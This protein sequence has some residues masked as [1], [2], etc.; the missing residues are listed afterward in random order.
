METWS[1]YAE[2]KYVNL[3]KQL[4]DPNTDQLEKET[5][6]NDIE[7]LENQYAKYA[8]YNGFTKPKKGKTVKLNL[9][10]IES[11]DMPKIS[12]SSIK[13]SAPKKLNLKKLKIE[14]KKVK[15]K[16]NKT[17]APSASKRLV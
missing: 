12:S 9:K 6:Q 4:N 3:Q 17:Q 2:Q 15:I 10:K 8:S 5:I 14:K 1:K 11:F 16:F 7:D 13:I